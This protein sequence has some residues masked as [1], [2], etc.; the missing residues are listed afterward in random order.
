MTA[1]ET[2]KV[3]AA[4]SA[5]GGAVR[6]V[7][8][9][10]RDAVLGRD[11]TDV[12]IATPNAPETVTRLLEA[13]G[14][15]AVPTG[16][17]HG[18][19]TAVVGRAHFEV[20][21]LRRDVETD[22]RHA[23]VT[24]TND[25]AAD[26]ARRDFTINAVFCDPDGTL[27]D[28]VGGLDDA[29]A[30]RVRF[31]GDAVR[32]IE[33][34]VLRLLRFFRFFAHFG[35]P[36]PDADA[37]AAC[38][39]MAPAVVGLSGERVRAELLKLLAA[40]DPAGVLALMDET[41]V[42]AHVMPEAAGIDALPALCAVEAPAADA[43][44]RLALLLRRGQG[45]AESVAKRLRMSNAE[46]RRLAAMVE[47]PVA[48]AAGRDVRDQ[49][50][51]LYRLGAALFADLAYL[52]WAEALAGDAS[53][54]DALARAHGALLETARAWEDPRLPVRGADVVALGVERGPAVSRLL[55]AIEDW[56][57][58]GDYRASRKATLKKLGELAKEP[59]TI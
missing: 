46:A 5:E 47:P 42:L 35:R 59:G 20:T 1:S 19:I 56:W 18:T 7:G 49:R 10:V 9:C 22:G 37:L 29:R 3:V 51:A 41:G 45:G 53:E 25:W 54:R 40:P 44:R 8:G 14:I 15:K 52:A 57:Q 17:E 50:R 31:V 34:D 4:L 32:R 26:A 13:A 48:V 38:R 11:V 23:T 33:E 2:K 58:A 16:I 27:F 55:A 12:D 28:P 21:T 43:L 6:F 36:P 30:G 24:F 39:K